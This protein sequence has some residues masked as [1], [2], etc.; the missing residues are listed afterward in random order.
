[1]E[2]RWVEPP[3]A[4]NKK[5]DG[6][7]KKL[8]VAV[9]AVAVQFGLQCQNSGRVNA[10]WHDRTGNARSGLFFAVDGF[11]LKPMTGRVTM[12]SEL[13]KDSATI[14]GDDEHLV[15][16]FGHTM[17]YGKYLEL[18]NGGR[19]A[20]VMSTVESHLPGLERMLKALLR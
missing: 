15:I 18:S 11:G 6:Y 5:I 14:S 13:G 10:P 2:F 1:M 12:P 16:G 19:Y 9:Q 17:Y 3:S 20:I 7:Q 8:L 4:L